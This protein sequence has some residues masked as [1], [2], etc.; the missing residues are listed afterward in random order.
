MRLTPFD[1]ISVDDFEPAIVK[2][3]A[4][5]DAEI[6]AIAS[7]GE[8]PTFDNTILALERSGADLNRVLGVFFPLLGVNATDAMQAVSMRVTPLLSRHS[9]AITLNERLWS[10]VKVAAQNLEDFNDED[11]RLAE[12][13][14]AAF[15]RSGATLEGD[16]RERY[17]EITERLSQLSL[18]FEQ[19]VLAEM[20]A[21]QL[22][23]GKDDLA[24]LP[25]SIV[26]A[27]REA[28]VEAGRPDQWLITLQA[29]SYGPFM[30]YSARRD[31][32]Q[33]LYM[34]YNTLCSTG[35][36]SN[37]AILTEI[38]DL[39]LDLARLMGHDT[40][41]AYRLERMM[42]GSPQV[43][44]DMLGKLRETYMPAMRR[45]MDELR[46]FA[47]RVDGSD[48]EFKPWDYSYYYNKLRDERFNVNDEQLRTYFPLERVISGVF[49]LATRLYGLR[50]TPIDDAPVW[51][52]EVKVWR[53][54]D[55][56]D[57]DREVGVLYAD[58]FPRP[59][60]QS[61]AWMTNIIEQHVDAAGHDIRPHV[62]LA[63]NFSRP[64]GDKPSLLTF[65]EVNTFL[66]EFGHCLHG[67][68]SRVRHES[69]SGTNVRRDFVELP[70]Q[71]NENFLRHREFIDS[72]AARYDTGEAVPDAL[73]TGKLAS[74]RF[75]AGYAC[76]RQLGFGY[77][78]MAWHSIRVAVSADDV[79]DYERDA[80]AQVQVFEPIGECMMSPHFSHIFAGGYAAGY[81]GYKWAEVLDADAFECFEREGIFNRD[82]ARRWR[83][84]VLSRGD[85]ADPMSLYIAFTGHEPRVDA[86]LRRDFGS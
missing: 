7:N 59:V 69:L 70:S 71:L 47:A 66:H 5:H 29:P 36:H 20:A 39:R 34:A 14:V 73:L 35:E 44:L 53:V 61:G 60:K 21:Y 80:M 58:F 19:N 63:T 46:E 22:W 65:G 84:C 28:A 24:G 18:Q 43:V 37:L 4:A 12:N 50:F 74:M 11:R 79:K 67:L 85:T 40:F 31:L 49:G 62:M 82:T 42:A 52:P 33:R 41:A 3:I 32:R 15:E 25:E 54:T 81:Y 55:G 38:A 48:L 9:S 75:G 83:D 10:R 1:K 77:L 8:E 68:L 45:E 17:R 51:H 30:K 23:L 26:E 2:A 64:T 78:D 16:A 57:H 56:D 86:L 72:F 76:V 27:A 13:T 6:E